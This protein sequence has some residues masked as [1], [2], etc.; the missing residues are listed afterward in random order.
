MSWESDQSPQDEVIKGTAKVC[1]D[2]F[3]EGYFQ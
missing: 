2:L 3:A 1:E